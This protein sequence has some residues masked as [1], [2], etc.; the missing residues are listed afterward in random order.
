MLYSCCL[1]VLTYQLSTLADLL[2]LPLTN[3]D[4][5]TTITDERQPAAENGV[6]NGEPIKRRASKKS[7]RVAAAAAEDPRPR[8]ASRP[9]TPKGR[10]P[11]PEPEEIRSKLA[12]VAGHGKAAS[13]HNLATEGHKMAADGQRPKSLVA[14]LPPP[15]LPESTLKASPSPPPPPPPPVDYQPSTELTAPPGVT[16]SS[17]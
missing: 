3:I 2:S 7:S 6:V 9:N 12:T 16:M 14:P 13:G 10:A 17:Y 11:S 1:P 8:S 4:H 15:R 5:H